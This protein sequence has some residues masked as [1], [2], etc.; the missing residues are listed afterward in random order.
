MELYQSIKIWF[1]SLHQTIYHRKSLSMARKLYFVWIFINYAILSTTADFFYSAGNYIPERTS[2]EMSG[3]KSIFNILN[4]ESLNFLYPYFI[5]LILVISIFGVSGRYQRWTAA[6]VY[7]L[8]MNL[9]NK[10]HVILDGGNNLIHLIGFYLIFIDT[11]NLKNPLSIT[12][13][14]LARL[15]ILIQVCLIYATAGL[16]KVMGPLWNKGV[17]LYYTMGV[18]EFGNEKLFQFLSDYP[19]AVALFT[20]GT[21][22]F[23]IS[24]PYLIWNQKLKPFV[25]TIG[26]ALHLSIAF[27]M[28]LFMFGFAMCLGYAFFKTDKLNQVAA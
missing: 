1:K 5:V 21:V 19:L 20:L 27:V 22:L 23:Q 7:L 14:N 26:T 18:P 2:S 16:L 4:I 17:A 28:G 24:F 12:L 11:Q 8:M 10:A 13:T 15:M 3:Y 6:A 25:I 9:D